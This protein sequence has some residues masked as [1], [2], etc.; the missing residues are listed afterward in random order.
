MMLQRNV[1]EGEHGAILDHLTQ[2]VAPRFNADGNV[3]VDQKNRK[4]DLP[5]LEG[6]IG[7]ELVGT[8]VNASGINLNR[9]YLRQAAPEMRLLH[10]R[11]VQVWQPEL[12][13]DCHATNGSVHRYDMAY[14]VPHTVGTGREEPLA[15]LHTTQ[16]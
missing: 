12:T 7:P 16:I 10:S 9:D 15:C 11:V 2:V 6:Q 4:L 8:R 3:A 1:L 13:I 14:H 5:K